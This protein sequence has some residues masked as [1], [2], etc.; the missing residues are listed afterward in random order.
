MPML[1]QM[2]GRKFPLPQGDCR[3]PNKTSLEQQ[4]NSLMLDNACENLD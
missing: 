2:S 3:V 4:G 1:A